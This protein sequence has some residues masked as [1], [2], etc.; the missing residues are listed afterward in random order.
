MNVFKTSLFL[1]L[2]VLANQVMAQSQSIRG[3]VTDI[4]SGYPIIGVNV[5][6]IG[7]DPIKGTTT[8]IDGNYVLTNV[9]L[10][11]VSLKYTFIGYKEVS[12][13]DQLLE[14]GKELFLNVSLEEEV[15]SMNEV[16]VVA[17]RS[18]TLL[19][20]DAAVVAVRAFD[21]QETR[22]YAGTRNDIARMA[23]NYAG[24]ANTD[25]S[26]NDIIIR[27]NSPTSLLWRLEGIDIP[28]PNHYNAFGT[29]GGPVGILNNNNLSNSDFFTSAFP[30]DYGNT[31][32]GVFDLQL[33][34]G[35]GFKGEYMGQI[36]FNGLEFGLEGPLNKEKHASYVANY[37]F[38]TLGVFQA[39]G[40]DFGTGTAVPKYQDLTF[41]IDLPSERMGS[42][43]LFG[44]GGIS[45][46]HLES[47]EESDT[48]GS[49]YTSAEVIN[50]ARVGVIG[51]RHQYFFNKRTN[52][53]TTIAAS[54]QF[55]S[56]ELDSIKNNPP[57]E[58]IK[59]VITNQTL[60]KYSIH[61]NLNSKLSAQHKVTVGFMV[62]NLQGTFQDS[63]L[64]S[65]GTWFKFSDTDESS[66]LYQIYGN[67][68]WK[69][70][71]QMKLI[72]G[73]HGTYMSL[74][75]SKAIEPRF[76]MT[77]RTNRN[78]TFSMGYG[79]HSQM[80][81]ILAY[82]FL[83]QGSPTGN[84]RELDFTRSHHF[85]LE[86]NKNLTQNIFLKLAG[87]Y[88][89]IFDA[90]VEIDPTSFSLLNFGT[91]FYNVIVPTLVNN[92][93]GRNYGLE[94]TLEKYFSNSYYFLL[95]T[96]LFQSEYQGSD[97][98]W[99]N[100]AFNTKHIIN[101]LAG[102]EF[103]V[104]KSGTLVADLK[105]TT[106]GGRYVTPIDLEASRLAGEAV[107]DDN[108]SFSQQFDNYFRTDFKI[109]YRLNGKKITQEW[110]IDTQN[111]F[112][113]DNI[114]DQVYNPK[115]EIIDTQY[116]VGRLIIPQ[117]RILF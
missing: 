108:N 69:A 62:D 107:Y 98:I 38:S 48:L 28:S 90:P 89:H 45:S 42:F 63:V 53:S 116:Q 77:Y 39:L 34:K 9:S 26:R 74:N 21:V 59:D 88:Q 15:T 35:N 80:Q 18:P 115:T 104:G 17:E 96:S 71:D 7:S 72:V 106:S 52:I 10:G 87:Y 57:D 84:N 32:S 50:K 16:V 29:T 78:A 81:P 103:K 91:S 67:Y 110:L 14:R 73:L 25:D 82:T 27:G 70:S 83:F 60:N 93:F 112:N 76:G 58:V 102:K 113:N 79:L 64:L 24:V 6:I 56:V 36:G 23:S 66:W 86:Y 105:L 109:G 11:R 31:V 101:L 30:A 65:S 2:I 3:K 55:T 13:Y 85:T 46:V 20:N 4:D 97:M 114:F 8:D 41:A 95:T 47:T 68:Q 1:G 92:G 51:I 49:M 33:R 43:K 5:V 54:Q 100:T 75:G 37:R 40:V 99:R 94:V 117:Y 61:T 19:N 111:L 44:L 12:L 22:R